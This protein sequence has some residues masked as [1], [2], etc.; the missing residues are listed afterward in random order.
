MLQVH[1]IGEEGE[2]CGGL[3]RELFSLLFEGIKEWYLEGQSKQLVLRHD[4]VALQVSIYVVY[5]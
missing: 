5:M 4:V 3:R 2:D 1:F